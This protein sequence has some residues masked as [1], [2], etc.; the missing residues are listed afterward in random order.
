M[1]IYRHT[2]SQYVSEVYARLAAK[3][4]S[5]TESI[6]GHTLKHTCIFE[7]KDNDA[8]IKKMKGCMGSLGIFGNGVRLERG[9]AKKFVR[10]EFRNF[11]PSE[12]VEFPGRNT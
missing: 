10:V 2:Y 8:A 7:A 11:T 1:P 5:E 6:N 4:P 12:E 9:D 3:V